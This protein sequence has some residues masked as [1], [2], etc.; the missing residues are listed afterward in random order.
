MS[1]TATGEPVWRRAVPRRW[2]LAAAAVVAI[3]LGSY[4]VVGTG[5]EAAQQTA[6]VAS[7]A[8][9]SRP[10]T[11]APIAP[12][13][14]YTTATGSTAT[15]ASLRG[16]PTMVWFV[17]G[18]CASCAASIPDVASHLGAITR[19]GLRVLTLGLYGAFAPGR[20]G[21]AQLVDFAKS[22]A[23]APVE[24]P[25]WSWG[26][27]S[28]SLS[29]AYDPADIPDTYVLIGSG[30]HL[31]YRNSVPDST[32]HQLLAASSRLAARTTSRP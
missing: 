3:G 23:G 25:G 15:I 2:A 13:G 27:A 10:A 4:V 5:Q 9:L 8:D 24:R 21:V 19:S 16:A 14:T 17:A 26:M 18:G 1:G 6:P 31:R 20:A 12:N 28:K 30:G 11:N 32:M 29:V 22:A 7:H